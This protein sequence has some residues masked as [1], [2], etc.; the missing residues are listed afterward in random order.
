MYALY[1]LYP[2]YATYA[3]YAIQYQFYPLLLL[4]PLVGCWPSA[5]TAQAV[6]PF[7]TKGRVRRTCFADSEMFVDMGESLW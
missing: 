6:L 5:S 4:C 1:A 3:T 7:Y 2:L